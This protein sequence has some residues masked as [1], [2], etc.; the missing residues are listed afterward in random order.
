MKKLL[1]V[2]LLSG[3]G[4]VP[5]DIDTIT[6]TIYDREFPLTGAQGK[7]EEDQLRIDSAVVRGCSAGIFF[8]EDCQLHSERSRE[9]YQ[10]LQ[11]ELS[12]GIHAR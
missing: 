4:T 5:A 12:L 9:R 3:C 6:G 2:L 1:I 11:Q 10:E 7:T 8:W